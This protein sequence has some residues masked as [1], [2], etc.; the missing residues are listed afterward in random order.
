[1]KT[2]LVVD[3]DKTLLGIMARQ[4]GAAYRVLTADDARSALDAICTQ[5]PD[6]VLLDLCL[7]GVSGGFIL[8]AARHAVPG[9]PIALVTGAADLDEV[10]RTLKNGA[11]GCLLKP[12]SSEELLDFVDGLT[13]AEA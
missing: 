3:D 11:R 2:V 10:E 4:L 12:F 13:A 7:P 8:R 6:L 5:S 1:M 9:L